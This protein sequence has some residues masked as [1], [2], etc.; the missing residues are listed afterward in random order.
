MGHAESSPINAWFQVTVITMEIKNILRGQIDNKNLFP[1]YQRN[2]FYFNNFHRI[3]LQCFP[4]PLCRSPSNSS[5]CSIPLEGR[6]AS[7]AKLHTGHLNSV[8]CPS[9][10]FKV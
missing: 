10:I 3:L 8:I 2:Q 9:A 7:L 6:S 5:C 1:G 4:L